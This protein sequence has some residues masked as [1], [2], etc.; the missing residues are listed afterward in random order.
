MQKFLKDSPPKIWQQLRMTHIESVITSDHKMAEK[1]KYKVC[2][3]Y[4][5][6][7]F[8]IQQCKPSNL[9]YTAHNLRF[10]GPLGL[11]LA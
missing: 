3:G 4:N 1:R 5:N 7:Y 8:I 6:I 10:E 2:I 11:G 9:K